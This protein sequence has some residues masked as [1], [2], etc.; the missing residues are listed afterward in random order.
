MKTNE[1][2]FSRIRGITLLTLFA[3]TPVSAW[4]ADDNFTPLFT[5]SGLEHCIGD[6]ES[7]SFQH[8]EL[9]ARG[10]AGATESKLLLTTERFG[11]FILKALTCAVVRTRD[12]P[13]AISWI[14]GSTHFIS[15]P[16]SRA[17]L[18]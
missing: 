8:G 16:H 1:P 15:L 17:S 11:N 3:L 7:W 6:K 12:N 9:T 18:A 2:V 14:V 13:Q 4:V 10:D 5:S